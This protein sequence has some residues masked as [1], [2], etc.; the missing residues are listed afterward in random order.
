MSAQPRWDTLKTQLSALLRMKGV[1]KGAA[2]SIAVLANTVCDYIN[3][4]SGGPSDAQLLEA[5]SLLARV[6]HHSLGLVVTVKDAATLEDRV[7]AGGQ[8][9][10]ALMACW[11]RPPRD[12]PAVATMLKALT[13]TGESF[14][15]NAAAFAPG[16]RLG[17][18]F[19]LVPVTG[20]PKLAAWL[21]LYLVFP[22]VM[23]V[24]LPAALQHTVLVHPT[25]NPGASAF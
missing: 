18:F 13:T 3:A 23:H 6:V 25:P 8:L 15:R 21:F 19:L 20:R 9:M 24:L 1:D 2:L 5:S 7:Y 16:G 12:R 22:C 4:S 11:Q 10:G 14:L 17:C